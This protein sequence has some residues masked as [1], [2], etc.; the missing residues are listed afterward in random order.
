MNLNWK[1]RRNA[2]LKTNAI[3]N[4]KEESV[5]RVYH[6]WM[7][8]LA[9]NCLSNQIQLDAGEAF[10]FEYL[11]DRVKLFSQCASMQ[12]LAIKWMTKAFTNFSSSISIAF[13]Y[14]GDSLP[15]WTVNE[16]V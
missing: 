6:I 15:L 11:D 16:Y 3:P 5:A 1:R 13:T 10:H 8:T 14:V 9:I 12:I 2:N 7:R 4:A